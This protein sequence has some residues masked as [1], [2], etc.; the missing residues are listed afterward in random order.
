MAFAA[1]IWPDVLEKVED[2]SLDP[3][4]AFITTRS[5]KNLEEPPPLIPSL[6]APTSTVQ[7]KRCS[8]KDVM[9]M[10]SKASDIDTED[11]ID[12]NRKKH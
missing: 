10:D 9:L 12:K 2:E 7:P 5:K 4:V 1:H 3:R 8:K 11:E 6:P